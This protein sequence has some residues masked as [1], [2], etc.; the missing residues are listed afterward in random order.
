MPV[1]AAPF[2]AGRAGMSTDHGTIDHDLLHI[3]IGRKTAVHGFPNAIGAPALEAF[4]DTVP[5]AEVFGQKAPLSATT[6]NPQY[7]FY[8]TATLIGIADIRIGVLA[9][10]LMNLFPLCFR[11]LRRH[12]FTH[13]Q[14]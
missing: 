2:C 10:E 13:F 14:E 7:A 1:S 9:E 3:G 12:I 6:G 5:G 4:I 11:E 8:E